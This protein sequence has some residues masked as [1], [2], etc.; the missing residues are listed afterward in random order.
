M[1]DEARLRRE[2]CDVGTRLWERGL[3][4]AN[5]GNITVRIAEDLLLATPAGLCKG[6]LEPDQLVVIRTDGTPVSGGQPSSEIKLHLRCYRRRPDCVAVVHAHPP[7]ATAFT[8]AEDDIPDDVLPES[9]FVL[10]PV[11]VVPFGFPG[12]EELPD[13]LEPFL[14][15]HKTFLLSHHGALTMGRNVWDACDRMETLERVATVLLHAKS[16]GRVT[17]MPRAGFS[18]LLEV[19]LDGRLG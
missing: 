5:E 3:V 14:D 11:A 17:P 13:Q 6:Q 16:L 9:G 18:K 19:A 10:G 7:V 2:V 12:T 15:D 8:V 1:S 4:G